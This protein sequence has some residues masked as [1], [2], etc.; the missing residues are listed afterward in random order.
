MRKRLSRGLEKLRERLDA[1]HGGE[2]QAWLIGMGL[3]SELPLA[4]L[5]AASIALPVAMTT[6]SKTVLIASAAVALSFVGLRTLDFGQAVPADHSASAVAP[7]ATPRAPQ[8]SPST[9]AVAELET[10]AAPQRRP[11][12]TN[13]SEPQTAPAQESFL[14]RARVLD[15]EGSPIAAAELV[16]LDS[17]IPAAR[18]ADDGRFEL[19]FDSEQVEAGQQVVV[20]VRAQGFVPVWRRERIVFGHAVD[21]GEI[22]LEVAGF[23]HGRVVELSGQPVAGAL[24]VRGRPPRVKTG[25]LRRPLC[26]G[27]VITFG[28]THAKRTPQAASDSKSCRSGCGKSGGMRR[29]L[30]GPRG[31]VQRAATGVRLEPVELR[32]EPIGGANLVRGVV[33][34]P[35]GEPVPNVVLRWALA[36]ENNDKPQEFYDSEGGRSDAE[37]RFALEMIAGRVVDLLAKPS[38]TE[39]KLGSRTIPGVAVGGPEI[40]IELS[41]RRYLVLDVRDPSA[42]PVDHFRATLICEGERSGRQH[43]ES[44]EAGGHARLPLPDRP[45]PRVRHRT[46]IRGLC[47]RALRTDEQSRSSRGRARPSRS[48][49][50][51]SDSTRPARRRCAGSAVP[52][53]PGRGSALGLRFSCHFGR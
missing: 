11:L 41:Q 49:E 40:V 19:T 39:T 18:A 3:W 13:R 7:A 31:P 36:D 2:R 16:V 26:G 42:S 1:R 9:R 34:D 29:V 44:D 51:P 53:S 28:A 17:E 23:V 30:C 43:F 33:L 21:L 25:P 15:G 12:A 6:L 35:E 24:G 20:E 48:F 22:E 50:R 38:L 46:A 45:L 10:Q 27:P 14:L 32:I 5:R 4:P 47:R 37:G 8:P 52:Q